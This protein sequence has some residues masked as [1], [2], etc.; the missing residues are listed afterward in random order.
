MEKRDALEAVA[1]AARDVASFK[2]F[3]TYRWSSTYL[4]DAVRVLRERLADLDKPDHAPFH[5]KNCPCCTKP[6]PFTPHGP[7]LQCEE[8]REW[9]SEAFPCAPKP[10]AWLGRTAKVATAQTKEVP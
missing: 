10:S 8:C 2:A 6:S 4:T 9:H 3:N 5:A 1:A 7:M